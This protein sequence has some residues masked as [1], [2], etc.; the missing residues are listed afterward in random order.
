MLMWM[1]YYNR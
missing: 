1:F